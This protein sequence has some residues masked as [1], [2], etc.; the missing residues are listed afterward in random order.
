MGGALLLAADTAE[1]LVLAPHALPVS[2]L[3]A[4]IGAP[5]FIWLLLR[6]RRR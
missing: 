5:G 1:R 4:F 6:R 3:T 2:V